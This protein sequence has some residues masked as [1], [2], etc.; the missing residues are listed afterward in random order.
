M[1]I[2]AKVIFAG[3]AVGL[4]LGG[5]AAGGPAG[6]RPG[7]ELM[8]TVAPQGTDTLFLRADWSPEPGLPADAA[9][10]YWVTWVRNGRQVKSDTTPGLSDSV[11]IRRMGTGVPDTVLVSLWTL[12]WGVL[13][14]RAHWQERIYRFPGRVVDTI[15]FGPAPLP[16]LSAPRPTPAADQAVEVPTPAPV[17]PQVNAPRVPA[18]PGPVRRVVLRIMTPPRSWGANGLDADCVAGVPAEGPFTLIVLPE[19]PEHCKPYIE[20]YG[21]TN[22]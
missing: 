1:R 14:R 15:D 13:S 5:C 8:G 7:D 10:T 22:P 2:Y 9:L 17:T 11:R 18:K 12:N 6:V 20:A 3:V 16:D 21:V 19:T 4:A